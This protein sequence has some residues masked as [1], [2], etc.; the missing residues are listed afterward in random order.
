MKTFKQLK[1]ELEAYK[2]KPNIVHAAKF[3]GNPEDLPDE[4]KNHKMFSAS[5]D[6]C[7]I[8]TLEGKMK[9]SKGDFIVIGIKDD[10]FPV[11]PDIFKLNYSKE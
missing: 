6:S 2:R 5:K 3:T 4:I 9:V 7:F 1:E 11:K 8:N 10:M